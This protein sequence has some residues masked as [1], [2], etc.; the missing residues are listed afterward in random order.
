MEFVDL[1]NSTHTD[2]LKDKVIFEP[3]RLNSQFGKDEEVTT[4][5]SFYFMYNT[6]DNHIYYTETSSDTIVL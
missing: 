5:D 4:P 2:A 3:H 1:N 6:R